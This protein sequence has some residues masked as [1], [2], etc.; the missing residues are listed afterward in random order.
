M[1][2]KAY[3]REERKSIILDQFYKLI[4]SGRKPE[5]TI[6]RLAQMMGMTPSSHLRNIVW[7]LV[8]EGTLDSRTEVHRN[9]VNKTVFFVPDNLYSFPKRFERQIMVN[10]IQLRF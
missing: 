3:S 6:Y 1:N 8:H 5:L 4:D 2:G 10:G 9:S 7:E